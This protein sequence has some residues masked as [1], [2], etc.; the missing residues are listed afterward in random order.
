M[1]APN[2][3]PQAQP[4]VAVHA[5]AIEAAVH[6]GRPDVQAEPRPA[7]APR[8]NIQVD[9]P[10]QG[11]NPPIDV[12]TLL[13]RLEALERGKEVGVDQLKKDIV[14]Y[15]LRQPSDFDKYV[16]L[17]MVERLKIV[18][19]EKRDAK[20]AFYSTVYASLWQ[21]IGCPA[22][23]FRSYMLA[24]LG[25]RDY[26]RVVEAIGKV[27]KVFGAGDNQRGK[28]WPNHSRQQPPSLMSQ[29]LRPGPYQ[30]PDRQQEGRQRRCF[31]CNATGHMAACC[32]RRQRFNAD[33]GGP[34]R[35]HKRY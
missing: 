19:Q 30:V 17:D 22:E 5:D 27:D 25:D 8:E 21:R 23:Q 29:P 11:E 2:N 33:G 35:P 18:A 28:S 10:V 3:G 32:F 6:P 15:A 31:I 4:P 24:L 1:A 13:R 12:E 7:V 34:S 20:T 16:A 26:E 14:Q 9:P